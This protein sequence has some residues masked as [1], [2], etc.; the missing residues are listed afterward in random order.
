MFITC[1]LLKATAA[2]SPVLI[3]TATRDTPSSAASA[4]SSSNSSAAASFLF[5]S[6]P[7]LTVSS[8][9]KDSFIT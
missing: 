5:I 1:N 6:V 9:Q 3:C 2:T 7:I 8:W 4:H